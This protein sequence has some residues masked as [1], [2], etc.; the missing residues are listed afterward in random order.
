MTTVELR[1]ALRALLSA[2]TG[3]DL[4]RVVRKNRTDEKGNVAP[5]PKLPYVT[6]ELIV[7]QP[8]GTADKTYWDG[9]ADMEELVKERRRDT[10][11]VQACGPGA[12]DLVRKCMT[13]LKSDSAV[14]VAAASK[15]QL[16]KPRG[17][18]DLSGDVFSPMGLEEGI[19]SYAEERAGFEVDIGYW[20][21]SRYPVGS[22]ESAEVR[23]SGDGEA[24]E[25]TVTA[26]RN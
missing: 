12:H 24:S 18:R 20:I 13:Y 10:F 25:V 1:N 8:V 6:Y 5:A 19:A 15:V 23:V 2:G 26:R 14:M 9:G 22:M 7:G 3:L 17:A 4:K 21:H 11:S 16:H